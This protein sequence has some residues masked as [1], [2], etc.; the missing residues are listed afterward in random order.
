MQ[1][2]RKK[3]LV[4]REKIYLGLDT[5]SYIARQEIVEMQIGKQL[6]R[7]GKCRQKESQEREMQID[8]ITGKIDVD[9]Y[10]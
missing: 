8:R 10:W 3:Y 7:K 2:E 6:D 4:K 1:Q 9:R 5:K